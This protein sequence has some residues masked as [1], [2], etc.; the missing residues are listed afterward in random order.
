M[1]AKRILGHNLVLN[2]TILWLQREQGES[3]PSPQGDTALLADTKE[4]PRRE[5]IE[6]VL[7]RE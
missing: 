6:S 1:D 3:H 7:R 2:E 4:E 5:I